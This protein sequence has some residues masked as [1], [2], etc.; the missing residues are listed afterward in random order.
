MTRYPRDP[1]GHV[2]PLPRADRPGAA[3]IIKAEDGGESSLRHGDTAC[4]AFPYGIAG[5]QPRHGTQ[6]RPVP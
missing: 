4:A 6:P 2:P 3:P 5:A 1:H